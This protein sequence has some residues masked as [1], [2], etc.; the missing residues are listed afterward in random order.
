M[1]KFVNLFV[2]FAPWAPPGVFWRLLVTKGSAFWVL[3]A[4]ARKGFSIFV[5]KCYVLAF[6]PASDLVKNLILKV[7]PKAVPEA[8]F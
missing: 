5:Q 2:F 1:E 3:G 8:S 4:A 7:V 6:G